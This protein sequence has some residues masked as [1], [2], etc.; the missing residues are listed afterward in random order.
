MAIATRSQTYDGKRL[1]LISGTVGLAGLVL[2]II[3]LVVDTRAAMFSYLAAF[4]Y[5]TSLALGVLVF[6][7]IGHAMGA[8]WVI[9]L[10]R[11]AT[12]VTG[13]FPMLALLFVPIAVGAAY[14]YIWIEPTHA[15]ALHAGEYP[16]PAHF[17]HLLHHKQPYLNWPFFVV[18]TAVFFGAW[19]LVAELLR[20]WS[21][22]RERDA[23][24]AR[25][26]DH[27]GT[28]TKPRTG[29]ARALSA[30]MLPLVGL[31]LTFAAFD[32]LMSLEPAW[33]STMFGVYYFAGGFLGG[34]ALL[35]VLAHAARRTGLLN[36]TQLTRFHFH[37]LGRLLV[38]FVVFWAYIA[39]FQVMLI[40]IANK[41]EEVTFYLH[42]SAGS[43]QALSYVLMVGHFAIPFLLLL[44]R[45]IK[46]KPA[47]LSILAGWLLVM[48]YLDVYWLVL[49]VLHP[50]GISPHW[51]DL[52]ALA[53]VG[54]VAVSFASWRLR[55]M[56]MLDEGDP[57]LPEA[58][59]YRSAPG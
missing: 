6:V 50:Q 53:G 9:V 25:Q 29:H 21:L 51:L 30:G 59:A 24:R 38:G 36:E 46:H 2:W 34:L 31:C 16:P 8:R 28:A 42:R 17:E 11:L 20:H 14:L 7:M 55:G 47:L 26:S 57:H 56:T 13:T 54:G 19:I 33:F 58:I 37:A 45:S 40:N 18:R 49:P 12:A 3:G 39:F 22:R 23:V 10:R 1:F 41:P 4:A 32:W 52:A 44:P 5:V 35:T 27:E 15:L 48:H 43:W